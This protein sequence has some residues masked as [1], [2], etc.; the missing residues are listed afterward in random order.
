MNAP[1][2][3]RNYLNKI[4][5]DVGGMKALFVDQETM[6]IVSLV[7]TQSQILEKEVF[8]VRLIDK[9]IELMKKNIDSSRD[10]R[11]LKAVVL[12]RPTSSNIAN[13]QKLI[14]ND[15]KTPEFLEFYFCKQTIIL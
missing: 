5:Q 2:A 1:Q 12:A 11:H 4:L 7:L 9:Q 8:L 3:I 13:I 10:H 15:G 6:G 14:K